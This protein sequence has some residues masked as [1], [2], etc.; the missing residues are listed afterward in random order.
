MKKVI[1]LSTLGSALALASLSQDKSLEIEMKKGFDAYTDGETFGDWLTAAKMLSDLGDRSPNEW[2]PNYW[3]SYFYTQLTFSIP[4]GY[5]DKAITKTSILKASQDNFDKAFGK[6]DNMTPQIRSDFHALQSL[7]YAF[8]NYSSENEALKS[9]YEKKELDEIK[10]GIRNDYNN[11]LLDVILA[12]R[13]I[14]NRDFISTYAARNL[15]LKAK[16]IYD[17][18]MEP[19]YMSTHW[20]EQWIEHWMGQSKKGLGKLLTQDSSN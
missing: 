13:L 15:L 4:E 7:I 1:L 10:S 14:R 8:R 9:E 2:L 19:R 6:V 12:V 11:P 20:N 5:A 3:S 18:R 16:G 17:S